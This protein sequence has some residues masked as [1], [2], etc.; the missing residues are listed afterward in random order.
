MPAYFRSTIGDFVKTDQHAILGRLSRGH[1]E[2]GFT[3]LLGEATSAWWDSIDAL[4]HCFR[5]LVDLQPRSAMWELL[6]EFNVPRM[7]Q[8]IDVV[9]LGSECLAVIELKTTTLDRGALE[10]AEDYALGLHYFHKPS[11]RLEIF[12][13]AVSLGTEGFTGPLTSSRDTGVVHSCKAVR[14]EDLARE[15]LVLSGRP[16][17]ELIDANAWE[18]GIYFPVPGMVEAAVKLASGLKVGDI[19]L[20][21]AAEQVIEELVEKLLTLAARARRDCRHVVC[22]VTGVPGAGKTLVGLSLAFR[23]LS[24]SGELRATFMSG[25]GPLVR[26]LQEA[27]IRDIRTRERLRRADAERRARTLIQNIHRFARENFHGDST[28]EIVPLPDVYERVL[29]FDEAQRAWNREQNK[30]KFKRDISEPSML[31][32]IMGKAEWAFIVALVGGGQEINDGEAG[33]SAWGQALTERN[34]KWSAIASPVAIEG[35]AAVAGQRL[36]TADH[37]M[38]HLDLDR[39]LHLN[40]SV[41]SLRAEKLAQWANAVISGD[42]NGAAGLKLEMPEFPILITRSLTAARIY[43]SQISLGT[44]RWGLI[45]SSGC[46]RLRAE[47]LEP[48]SDFHGTYRWD[49]WF[50]GPKGNLLSSYQAEVFATEFEIQ[51]LE[52]DWA[53]ICWGGD[54]VRS[55]L[56]NWIARKLNQSKG[57]WSV[58]K[59]LE[60]IRFRTNAYRVLLTRSRIGTVIFV[61]TGDKKEPTRDP[62]E[63]DT[64]AE[65]LV[66]CGAKTLPA[67]GDQ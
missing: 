47:G 10:Q 31:L 49:H 13:F 53:C 51:G 7:P 58:I 46:M 39:E 60:K 28:S 5:A 37:P 34:S 12:V 38:V 33:L 50:L 59:S 29:I 63:F 42:R 20:A 15:L 22:F 52:L 23:N 27:L 19:A 57:K 24:S 40:V 55:S 18:H 64:I 32:E 43:L 67:P 65:F 2:D 36:F 61:P 25:N 66:Q 48:S 56:A 9:V 4:Q 11:E 44:Q 8:R 35:G 30:R 17:N 1:Q 54:F 41:R 6:L 21:E 26:V 16:K 62:S 3:A 14:I 45:G